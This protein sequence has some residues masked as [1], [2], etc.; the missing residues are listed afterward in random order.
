M[1]RIRSGIT[2]RAAELERLHADVHR[3]WARRSLSADQ[4]DAW[5]RGADR[6][7]L[8]VRDFY[9][10]FDHAAK[11]LRSGETQ[12]VETAV[13][14]LEA[15]PWCFR[16]GY[17]KAELMH[18]LANGPDLDTHHHRLHDVVGRRL[19]DPQPRLLRHT[20]RLA[21]AVWDDDLHQRVDRLPCPEP[22]RTHQVQLFLHL[23]EQRLRTEGRTLDGCPDHRPPTALTMRGRVVRR[24]GPGDRPARL[25]PPEWRRTI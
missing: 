16:S 22:A 19:T 8:A 14:F 1:T 9:S 18:R 3:L 4:W 5:A 10:P 12:E 13:Q 17:M 2:A 11:A 23:V 24:A 20:A 7:D 15:D 25:R 21:A 6:F